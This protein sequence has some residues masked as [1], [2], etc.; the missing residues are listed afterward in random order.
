ME[1]N[2]IM[3]LGEILYHLYDDTDPLTRKRQLLSTL[4]S[5][6]SCSYT[7]ILHADPAAEGGLPAFCDPICDP[8]SFLPAEEAYIRLSSE[9]HLL[10]SA[11]VGRPSI[12]RESRMLTDEKRLATPIYQNCYRSFD[13][14]DTLQTNLFAGEKFLGVLTLYRTRREGHFDDDDVF[15]MQVLTSH[16]VRFFEKTAKAGKNAAG[17]GPEETRSLAA[18]LASRY[19]LTAR[20]QEILAHLLEGEEDGKLSEELSISP[21]TLKKH[22]QHIYRKLGIQARWELIRFR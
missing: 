13:V 21:G 5:L 18:A 19:G 10:W 6:L 7:S 20:E 12:I 3:V 16:L 9:D 1:K 4:R 8:V 15:M 22:L 14:F 11:E 17:E 2:E